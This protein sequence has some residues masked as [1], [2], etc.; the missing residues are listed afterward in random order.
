[1]KRVQWKRQTL[2]KCHGD[3]MYGFMM[4]CV[5]RLM[6]ISVKRYVII[7]EVRIRELCDLL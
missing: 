4:V 3:M 7:I 5:T 1:M 6:I 2:K